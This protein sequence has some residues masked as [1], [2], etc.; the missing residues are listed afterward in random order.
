MHSMNKQAHTQEMAWPTK[1]QISTIG[2][3]VKVCGPRTTGKLGP[4][5]FKKTSSI[6]FQDIVLKAHLLP[7][8]V[9]RLMF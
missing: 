9:Q 8:L 6:S 7:C 3:P 2:L 5:L 1:L 4:E